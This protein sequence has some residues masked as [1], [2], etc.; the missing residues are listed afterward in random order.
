MLLAGGDLDEA[1]LILERAAELCKTWELHVIFPM[2]AQI[3]GLAYAMR[4]RVADALPLLEE[5]EAKAPPVRIYDTPVA[6]TAL[7]TGYLL[8]AK[9]DE[10]SRAASRAAELATKR[11]FRG[12]QARAAFLLGEISAQH[13]PPEADRAEEHYFQALELA[14]QLGMR[15]LIAHLHSSLGRL[16]QRV[17]AQQKAK[18]HIATAATMYRDLDMRLWLKEATLDA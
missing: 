10:A 2:T 7:G 13:D 14:Q 5:G 1:I 4:G 17:G 16:R 6:T 12:S 3:L 8:A 9:L 15:P 18:E 11:G